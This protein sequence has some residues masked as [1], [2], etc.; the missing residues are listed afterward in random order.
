MPSPGLDAGVRESEQ[1]R[2]ENNIREEELD[3]ETRKQEIRHIN[4]DFKAEQ[5]S[6]QHAY[7]HNISIKDHS[8]DTVLPLLFLSNPSLVKHILYLQFDVLQVL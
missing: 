6:A 8:P 3:L 1:R 2:R 4:V 7:K 5:K